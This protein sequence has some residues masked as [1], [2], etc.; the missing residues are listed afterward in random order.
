[1]R[2]F[3][4]KDAKG[5]YAAVKF[6]PET[7]EALKEYQYNNHIPNPLSPDEFHSTVMFSKKYIPTFKPLGQIPNWEGTFTKFD[8]FPS[9]EE[10]ALVLK[11][12]SYELSERFDQ[13]IKEYG[14]TWDHKSFIP[15]ITLS[16]N[17]DDL[18]I[19]K[20]PKYDGPIIIISEYNNDLDLGWADER[21]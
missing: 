5:S 17:V 20:L 9:D 11:Y 1:M 13:I 14:A 3:E 18:D 8:I 19:S 6:N 4:F 10:N 7:T 12:D 15:H 16:Y 21:K 2:L